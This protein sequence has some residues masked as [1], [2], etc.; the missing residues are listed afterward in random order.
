MSLAILNSSLSVL[1]ALVLKVQVHFT[2]RCQGL[3]SHGQ[4]EVSPAVLARPELRLLPP[5]AGNRPLPLSL[6]ITRD[7]KS[8]QEPVSRPPAR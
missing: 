6:V 4:S 8:S 1:T 5:Q 3:V 7:S 2:V